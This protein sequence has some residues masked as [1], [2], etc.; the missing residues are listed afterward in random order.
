MVLF[1]YRYLDSKGKRKKATLDA[2]NAAEAKEKLRS[3]G[4]LVISLEESSRKKNFLW[5]SQKHH[6]HGDTLTTFTSQLAQLLNAQVPLYDS[7]F[8]LEEQYRH[9]PF[10]YIIL[11]LRDQIKK[12]S[13]LTDAMKN[14]PNSFNNLYCA[15]VEAG[16][17]VGML[18]QT[19]EKLAAL[20]QKQNKL[21]KQIITALIYP[22]LLLSFSLVVVFLLLTFVIPSLENLFED[23]DVN[24]FT[25]I[26]IHFSHFF[27]HQW[28]I[29]LPLLGALIGGGL[30]ALFSPAGNRWIQKQLLRT[31]FIKTLIVQTAMERFTRTVGALLQG[32]VTIIQAL[33]IGRNVIRNP[34]LE[35]VIQ[36]AQQ[37]IIEGSLLSAELNKSPLIPSLIPRMLAI[38]E[39]GGSTPLM[40][41]RIATIYEEEIEKTISR[42]MALAQPVIL[43]IMGGIVGL[44]MLSVLLPLTDVSAFI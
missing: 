10:H 2:D 44:I 4:I 16:E 36:Q 8:S 17:S 39:E 23:R 21:K 37:K 28:M 19:L 1:Q 3:S 29:Y 25:K 26:V 7:L 33:E 18:D 6:L 32:G 30:Y 13:S 22:A 12:G 41:H 43:I 9:E 15:M 35:E 34:F 27:T 5:K 31:P 20:L 38:G 42:L 11:S 14:F 40:L 24:R